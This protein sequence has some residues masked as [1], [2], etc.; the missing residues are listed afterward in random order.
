MKR[1]ATKIAIALDSYFELVKRFPLRR[2][3]TA[4]Q[5]NSGAAIARGL[6]LRGEVNLDA[7]EIDYLEALAKFI[8]EYESSRSTL[9]QAKPLDVLKHLMAERDLRPGDLGELIGT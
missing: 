2:I 6:A 8:A 5:R 1:S 4:A 3:R 7:G 9:P